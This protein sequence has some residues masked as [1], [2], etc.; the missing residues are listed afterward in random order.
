MY[1]IIRLR[2]KIKIKNTLPTGT[3]SVLDLV[4]NFRP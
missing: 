1:D 3:G 4:Q 2:V